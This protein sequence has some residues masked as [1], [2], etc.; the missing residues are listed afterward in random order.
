MS[1]FVSVPEIF[2]I[3][4]FN[5]ATMRQYLAPDVFAA[6]EQCVNTSRPLE[7]E[8]A[9]AIAEAMKAWALQKGATH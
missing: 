9:N 2:G 5:T 3:D 6:W 4:V 8:T 7:L 1:E